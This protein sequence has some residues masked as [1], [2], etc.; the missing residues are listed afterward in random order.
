[1]DCRH[2]NDLGWDHCRSRIGSVLSP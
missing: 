2:C 1:L